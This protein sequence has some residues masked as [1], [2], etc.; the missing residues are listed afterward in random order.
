MGAYILFV[1]VIICKKKL[2]NHA[3]SNK[4]DLSLSHLC[5]H[6][7]TYFQLINSQFNHSFFHSWNKNNIGNTLWH[8]QNICMNALLFNGFWTKV[9][10]DQ[11][12]SQN[13]RSLEKTMLNFA[14]LGSYH[15]MRFSG[16]YNIENLGHFRKSNSWLWHKQQ[17]LS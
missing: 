8:R 1:F 12:F 14:N 6:K 15:S 10:F 17:I 11:C 3:S 9:R 13:H 4:N 16:T 7:N 5:V 2:F